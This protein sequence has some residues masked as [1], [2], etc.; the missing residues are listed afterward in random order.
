M[1]DSSAPAKERRTG[2]VPSILLFQW[3]RLTW[4]V[5]STS[6]THLW[7]QDLG[8]LN[9]QNVQKKKPFSSNLA[10]LEEIL[11]RLWR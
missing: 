3:C 1:T 5:V 9:Q 10:Q 2:M 11:Q 6:T 8:R 4:A 7:K